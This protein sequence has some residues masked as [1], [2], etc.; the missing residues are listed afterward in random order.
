MTQVDSWQLRAAPQKWP[1][2][3]RRGRTP[4][5]AGVCRGAANPVRMN[6]CSGSPRCSQ[7]ALIPSDQTP[8]TLKK[9]F[10]NDAESGDKKETKRAREEYVDPLPVC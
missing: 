10:I 7:V 9:V 8:V 3:L 6:A 4:A 5:D 1:V 2:R